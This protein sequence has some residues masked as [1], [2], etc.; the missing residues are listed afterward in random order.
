M[1][2]P[3]SMGPDCVWYS[4]PMAD[5]SGRTDTSRQCHIPKYCNLDT[6]SWGPQ[7]STEW[8]LY[9]NKFTIHLFHLIMLKHSIILVVGNQC[10]TFMLTYSFKYN[11]RDATLYNI[12]YCC[13][14]STCFRRF[15]RPSSGA[16]NCTLSI[17]YMPSLLPATA[18]GS[19]KQAIM[20][21]LVGCT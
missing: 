4:Q 9:K 17:W 11:Q 15:L 19:R 16:Q 3:V 1:W 14:C 21:H 2:G 8:V 5:P 18:S 10:L 20:L 7:V 6:Q 12:L 13:Q